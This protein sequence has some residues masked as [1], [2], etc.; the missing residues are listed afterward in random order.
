MKVKAGKAAIDAIKLAYSANLAV[1]LEGK[2]G[3]GKSTLL[4]QAA[5]ELGIDIIVRD[6]SLMEPP[7]LVGMPFRDGER[8]R[9][10]PPSFLPTGG[11]GLIVFE[12]LNRAD[13]SMTAPC[14]QLITS[15]TL[16]DYKLPSGWLPVAAINPSEDGYDVNDLDPALMSRFVRISLEADVKGW[17]RWAGENNVHPAVI[18][19]LCQVPGLF[20]SPESNPRSW[21]WVSNAVKAYAGG[22]DGTL[23]VVVAGLV[24]ETAAAAFIAS[25]LGGEE[26][27]TA[28]Q[29]LDDYANHSSTVRRWRD[30]KRIDL[31]EAS[32]HAVLVALQSSDVAVGINDRDVSRQGL[33]DFVEDLPA[34]IARKLK[35][36]LKSAGVRL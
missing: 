11:K 33:R 23:G 35:Q 32:S 3:I 30:G 21:T 14:L 27:L 7:D 34:D 6:L 16:N 26:P 24:G 29:V 8:T 18:R 28:R 2:H 31:C 36:A 15:R 25:Y 17:L 12:E 4:E 5:R 19:F 10:A 20:Y 22:D 9:Y 1:M 13:R